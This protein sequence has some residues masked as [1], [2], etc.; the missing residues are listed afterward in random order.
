[1]LV[2]LLE[3]GLKRRLAETE[4][5]DRLFFDE[6]SDKLDAWA[7]EA[8][9]GVQAEIDAFEKEIKAAKKQLRAL[10][11]L[12]QKA[13]EK[14][15]IKQLEKQRDDRMMAFFETR[16]QVEEQQEKFLDGIEAKMQV[17]T[18]CQPLFT[19]RWQLV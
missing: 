11:T 2:K 13:T 4:T 5:Q 6:E 3:S 17:K 12:E 16:R 9:Q 8:K 1:V 19:I 15:R 7:E 10:E 18:V 14:R